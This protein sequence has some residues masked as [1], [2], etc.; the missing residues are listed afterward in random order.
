MSLALPGGSVF[1]ILGTHKR[2]AV[3]ENRRKV[4]AGVVQLAGIK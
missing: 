2:K 1:H 4:L 3:S